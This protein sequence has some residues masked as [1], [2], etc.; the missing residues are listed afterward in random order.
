MQN[1]MRDGMKRHLLSALVILV[2]SIAS[3]PPAQADTFQFT[4]SSLS[5]SGGSFTFLPGSG[6]SLGVTNALINK[7]LASGSCATNCAISNGALNLASG[8]QISFD[9]STNSYTFDQGGSLDIVG[10]ISSLGIA[11]GTTLLSASFLAGQT[12]QLS[13]TTGTFRALLDPTSIVLAAGLSSQVPVSG[14]DTESEFKVIFTPATGIYSGAIAQSTV[15]I[16]TSPVSEPASIVFLGSSLISILG[17]RRRWL[18]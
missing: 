6:D 8:G 3:V 7:L 10:G 16:N 15:T 4:G 12:L 1:P 18:K 11:S 5:G 13:T 9:A 2:L 17:I 14:T